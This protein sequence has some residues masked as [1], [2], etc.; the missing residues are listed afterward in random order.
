MPPAPD[1]HIRHMIFLADTI[2]AGAAVGAMLGIFPPIAALAAAIWYLIQAW[3]SH[4]VQKWWRFH[5]RK[6]RTVRRRH[7]SGIRRKL[8]RTGPLTVSDAG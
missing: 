7:K 2:S 5:V 3:E 6:R 4:T 1:E 8:K